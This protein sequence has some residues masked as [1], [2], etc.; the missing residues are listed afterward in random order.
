V[1]RL[2]ANPVKDTDGKRVGT[3]VEWWDRS[4]EVE[5]EEEVASIVKRALANDLS[6]RV[7]TDGKSGFFASLSAGLNQLL[8]NT[9]QMVRDIKSASSTV[10]Q[11]A[12]EISKG[13]ENL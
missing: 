6:E 13:T 9:S 11:G 8:D 5:V 12:Q 7:P 10:H 4:Q 1:I 2:E 3:V